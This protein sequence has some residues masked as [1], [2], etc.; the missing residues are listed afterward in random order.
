MK[1]KT[2][3]EYPLATAWYVGIAPKT[4]DFQGRLIPPNKSFQVD[5]RPV[6]LCVTQTVFLKVAATGTL[7]RTTLRCGG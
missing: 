5:Y 3:A 1:T 7:A 2:V 4:H 6:V